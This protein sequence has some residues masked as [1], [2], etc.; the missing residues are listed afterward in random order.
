VNASGRTYAGLIGA[1]AALI[2]CT[3][4]GPARAAAPKVNY[5]SA[6]T[7]FMCTGCHE[8]LN[9]VNSEEAYSEKVFLQTLIS[10][11]LSM[12]QIKTEM[13]Q[14]Y[15]EAVLAAPPANG[16]NLT[17]YI[18]PP[19]V[20]I[21]GAG[22]LAYTLPKWRDRARRNGDRPIVSGARPLAADDA[23]R[24]DEELERFV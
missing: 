8:P 14:Q 1:L 5:Q 23:A 18:L 11:G 10:D 24:L 3:A 17:I 13:V 9:Q 12:G 16:F 7:Q 20:L 4:P 15:G 22:L 2:L 19:V 6:I 21:A